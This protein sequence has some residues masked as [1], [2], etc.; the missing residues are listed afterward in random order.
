MC[1][2][3]CMCMRF[4][5]MRRVHGKGASI[6]QK[7]FWSQ[8]L[9]AVEGQRTYSRCRNVQRSE[10]ISMN[11]LKSFLTAAAVMKTRSA[12]NNVQDRST[13]C[14]IDISELNFQGWVFHT[15]KLGKKEDWNYMKL[16]S[17]PLLC[18]FNVLSGDYIVESRINK[19]RINKLAV[20][21][22][23]KDSKPELCTVW[24]MLLLWR[25]K[26]HDMLP[27]PKLKQRVFC[28]VMVDAHLQ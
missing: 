10:F 6:L 4:R 2:H 26:G 28:F 24:T 12:E 27:P 5:W 11:V 17:F 14:F 13:Q 8:N 7:K 25:F 20:T 3:A 19:T 23:L 22:R 15:E 18:R 21:S 1:M 16:H 9:K